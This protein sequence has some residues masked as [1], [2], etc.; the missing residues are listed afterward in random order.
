MLADLRA[1]PRAFWVLVAGIFINRFGSFVYPFLTIFLSRRGFALSDVALVI[2]GFGLGGLLA[3]LAGGWFA[4]RFGRRNTIVAGT[5]ANAACVM[6]L[7]YAPSLASS[8]VLIFFAGVFGGFYQP[9]AGALV[10]DLI[11]EERRLAAY[12]VLRQAANAGF[13]FGTAA[14][15]FLVTYSAFWLFAGDAITTASY[16]IIAL[17]ALPHGLRH[18]SQQARWNEALDR[19]RRDARFWALFASQFLCALIFAQFA[20]S[21]ALEITGRRLHLGD[22]RPEQIFGAL[23]GWNGALVMLL[24]LPIT[25]LTQRFNPRRVMCL[26]YLLVGLGFAS[27]AFT[28]SLTG[29]ILGMTVF[30]VGEMLAMPMVSTWVAYLAPQS[31]R[32][33]YM[34]ALST[35]WSGANMI[36][37]MIGFRLFGFHP[38]A[39]W[40]SCGALGAAAAAIMARWGEARSSL[41]P[42]AA[43]LA[44]EPG[45]PA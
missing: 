19:L 6:A 5:L 39:L 15:G 3:A 42:A 34:G 44:L 40:L 38:S 10:A 21:Y 28:I 41:H 32:G 26:G 20:S 12:A 14:G 29:L 45:D 43:T 27:N 2:A 30:T 9:A 31:M 25:R 18:T 4:D 13:A 36:G 35:S 8:V 22:L 24:E 33:R 1:L 11:P 16:G 23:I 37:P 17:V 7:Y